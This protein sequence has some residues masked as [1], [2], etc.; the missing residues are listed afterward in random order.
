MNSKIISSRIK[1]I[2][3][4]LNLTQ[5]D[6]GKLINVAQTTLSS[7]END[8]QTPNI[9]TLYNIAEKCNVSIDW[10]CGRT[11]SINFE[12]T[13]YADVFKIISKIILTLES[14]VSLASIGYLGIEFISFNDVII[15]KF[16]IDFSKMYKLLNDDV[17]E[18]DMFN[19]WLNGKIDNAEKEV[20]D[21]NNTDIKSIYAIDEFNK[22]TNNI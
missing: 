13:T 20:I 4:I 14:G 18:E 22:E 16:L 9:E 3:N 6:F 15:N 17:I 7:Y 12:I 21:A 5:N 2:R 8:S 11:D 19:T 10:L 1:E